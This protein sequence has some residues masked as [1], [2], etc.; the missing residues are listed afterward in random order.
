MTDLFDPV[1][2]QARLNERFR[3][4]AQGRG[5]APAR[6]TMRETFAR[7]GPRDPNFTEQFQTSGFDAR[8]SELYLFAALDAAGLDVTSVGAAP[9]FL[10]RGHGQEWAIEVTTANP[11]GGVPPPRLPE[12]P[13]ELQRYIDGELAIRLGSALFSK[14]NRRY[15]E[16]PHVAGNPFVLAI[17]NFASEQS[18]QLADTALAHYLYGFRTYSERGP[19]GRLLVYT[20]DVD[21]IQGEG[22]KTIPSNFFATPDAE[23]ISAVLWTNSGTVAKFARMGFQR[24]LDSH[25]IHMERVG[26][27]H[28]PDPD[29]DLPAPFRYAVGDRWETWEEGLVMAHNPHALIP[30]REDAF[31]G[32]VHLSI[33]TAGEFRAVY[34]SFHAFMSQTAIVVASSANDGCDEP[35]TAAQN[36]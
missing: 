34:P 7:M 19:D 33:T 25:G 14:L 1:V 27:R 9:D 10:V 28:V 20:A 13:F 23:H 24:G 8:F 30:L 35:A 21:T 12:D 29:A 4:V 17:Q 6:A 18:L 16:L 22:G 15:W 2:P 31:P 32:I 26:L 3:L 5:Y 11:P 36:L